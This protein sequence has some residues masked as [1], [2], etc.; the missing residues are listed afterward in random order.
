MTMQTQDIFKAF[1]SNWTWA[2]ISKH[3]NARIYT[4]R[5]TV[6]ASELIQSPFGERVSRCEAFDV[7]VP[8]Y[9]MVPQIWERT[10]FSNGPAYETDQFGIPLPA[11]V[12][13]MPA[14]PPAPMAIADQLA[15][16]PPTDTWPSPPAQVPMPPPAPQTRLTTEEA[17]NGRLWDFAKAHENYV[18]VRLCGDVVFGAN[19]AAS[20]WRMAYDV[21]VDGVTHEIIRTRSQPQLAP[22]EAGKPF[23][24]SNIPPAAPVVNPFAVVLPFIRHAERYRLVGSRVTCNPPPLDTDQDVLVEVHSCNRIAMEDQMLQEGYVLE[25]SA[26]TDVAAGLGDVMD[27]QRVFTSMRKGSMNYILTS[28]PDFFQRFTAATE[29]AKKFNVLAKADRIAMFQA[30]LYGNVV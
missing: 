16:L 4:D 1:G 23:S 15:T 3:G 28:D 29:L 6:L 25:G 20:M 2:S 26:P 12:P 11:A 5:P 8:E 24:P 27:P 10:D 9:G 22:P 13:Q 30:V 7:P 14:P 19:N 18:S 21:V 17:E